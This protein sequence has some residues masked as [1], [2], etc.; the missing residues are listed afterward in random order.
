MSR[1]LWLIPQ[2]LQGET[3]TWSQP[4]NFSNASQLQKLGYKRTSCNFCPHDT[5]THAHLG[6]HTVHSPTRGRAAAQGDKGQ[7]FCA[8]SSSTVLR[9]TSPAA[10]SFPVAARFSKA[11]KYNIG[12][13]CSTIVSSVLITSVISGSHAKHSSTWLSKHANFLTDK[14]WESECVCQA[15]ILVLHAV[16]C[17]A[18]NGNHPKN[19]SLSVTEALTQVKYWTF[20]AESQRVTSGGDRLVLIFTWRSLSLILRA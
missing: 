3:E 6:R 16:K 5:Q 20:K 4:Q 1:F 11:L 17:Q 18:E 15:Q 8:V 10:R 12:T 19:A 13:I 7:L 14:S 9:K 2:A